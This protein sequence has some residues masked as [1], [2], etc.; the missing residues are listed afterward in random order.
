M[1]H[2]GLSFPHCRN[3]TAVAS[4]RQ[5]RL[6]RA[7]FNL[8]RG[9]GPKTEPGG[10]DGEAGLRRAS[11]RSLQAALGPPA[12]G[13]PGPRG[14][15]L[16]RTEALESHGALV[17]PGVL[18]LSWGPGPSRGC[19]ARAFRLSE[20]WRGQG[21]PVGPGGSLPACSWGG[22]G[23]RGREG[24]PPVQGPACCGT[25]PEPTLASPIPSSRS[26]LWSGKSES[27]CVNGRRRRLSGRAGAAC[28]SH[29]AGLAARMSHLDSEAPGLPGR[30]RPAWPDAPARPPGRPCSE[31]RLALHRRDGTAAG[32]SR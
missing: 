29:L 23:R 7:P 24:G 6:R 3:L 27:T 31:M 30:R 2:F 8:C 11:A 18:R 20:T 15:A 12:G 16:P 9:P 26:P 19:C 32:T 10:R 21:R 14:P 25:G 1:I 5:D 13:E 4:E 17:G 22:Q 28:P